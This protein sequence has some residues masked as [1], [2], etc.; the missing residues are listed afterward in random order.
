MRK[1]LKYKLFC[2]AINIL[3]SEKRRQ[4]HLN[5][6]VAKKWYSLHALVT[7]R[8]CITVKFIFNDVSNDLNIK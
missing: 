1:E 3:F 6:K 8:Y 7:I 4:L 2:F 5:A